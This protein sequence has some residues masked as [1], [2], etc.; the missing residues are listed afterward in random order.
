ML[1]AVT[2]TG[3]S[4]E[5]DHQ[6]RPNS[7]LRA[8]KSPQIDSAFPTDG[9]SPHGGTQVTGTTSVNDF[10]SGQANGSYHSLISLRWVLL[11]PSG[12]LHQPPVTH[13]AWI[14]SQYPI[15]KNDAAVH[16]EVTTTGYSDTAPHRRNH[17][18]HS[19]GRSNAD[20]NSDLHVSI[21]YVFA[22]VWKEYFRATG[23]RHQLGL[24]DRFGLPAYCP[25]T[26]PLCGTQVTGTTSV[27]DFLSGQANGSRIFSPPTTFL[28]PPLS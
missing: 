16:V 6:R 10:L 9:S 3:N 12:N 25:I 15:L 5:E 17:R 18:D 23:R 11:D 28:H 21:S 27:N 24:S 1:L 2:T 22:C 4:E 7:L 13:D 26:H 20:Q 14:N 8:L 19:S